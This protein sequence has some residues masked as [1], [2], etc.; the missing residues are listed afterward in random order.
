MIKY[1]IPLLLLTSCYTQ[2]KATVQVAKAD[3]VYPE[4]TAKLCADKFKP[5]TSFRVEIRTETDT[6][7]DTQTEIQMFNDTVYLTCTRTVTNTVYRD[8]IRT[9]V[10]N[11]SAKLLEAQRDNWQGKYVQA[12]DEA[13]KLRKGRNTWMWIGISGII[14][15][16]VGIILY[17][18]GKKW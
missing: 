11:A 16:I 10:D 12:N 3:A 14:L 18:Y 5:D 13:D 17:I 8:S 2:H 1:L 15:L 6:V 7:F 4:V 9:I